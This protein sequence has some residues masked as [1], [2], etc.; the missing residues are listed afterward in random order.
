MKESQIT[1]YITSFLIG[2]CLLIIIVRLLQSKFSPSLY[3]IL[4][5]ILLFSIAIGIHGL[6]YFCDKIS[7]SVLFKTLIS[8]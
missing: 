3:E 7:T 1:L 5:L 8:K 4:V 2:L 6:I